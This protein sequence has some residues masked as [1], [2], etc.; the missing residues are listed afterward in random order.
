MA[1]IKAGTRIEVSG[2]ALDWSPTW[3]AATI[4]RPRAENLPFPGEGWHLVRFADGGKLC[5]HQ[6]RFRVV[7]NRE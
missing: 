4:A 7:D 5:I 6:S 1:T 3:E 2:T